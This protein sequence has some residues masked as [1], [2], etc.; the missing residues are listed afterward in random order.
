MGLLYFTFL[1]ACTCA[2]FMEM[3]LPLSL[4]PFRKEKKE[5]RKGNEENYL[6]FHQVWSVALA[7]GEGGGE[8]RVKMGGLLDSL[9]DGGVDFL[10]VGFTN[11]RDW[12]LLGLGS[13]LVEFLLL[14][15]CRLFRPSK[16]RLIELVQPIDAG[17][18]YRGRGS[19]DVAG[20]YAAERNAVDLE[21]T[22]D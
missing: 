18:I 16:I 8:V 14:G 21:G 19:D 20:I 1:E 22:G 13:T 7:Q 15:L 2:G 5:R 3:D 6:E 4:P 12:L 11:L 10:L 17:E 9:E